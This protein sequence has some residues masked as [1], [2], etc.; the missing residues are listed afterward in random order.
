M[1]P[2]LGADAPSGTLFGHTGLKQ[3]STRS[4]RRLRAWG[5][6]S[7][8]RLRLCV[9]GRSRQSRSSSAS[10]PRVAGGRAVALRKSQIRRSAS[11]SCLTSCPSRSSTCSTQKV[12]DRWRLRFS[13]TIVNVGEGDFILRAVRNLRGGWKAEQDIPYS[14]Q[15]A[16]RVRIPA[17]LVWGGDGH[18]HWHINRVAVV[19]L[20]PLAR[21]W[22]CRTR[23]QGVRRREGRVLLLRLRARSSRAR[24]P[25]AH[26][27]RRAAE[28]R[29]GPSWE[30]ASPPVG[31]T[32]IGSRFGAVDRRDR[33][34]RREVPPF[35]RH[36]SE[37]LVPRSK[38]TEQSHVDR[39]RARTNTARTR[40]AEDQD[41]PDPRAESTLTGPFGVPRMRPGSRLGGPW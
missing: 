39:H 36:R 31:T 15:G 25:S 22:S 5:T 35:H 11:P 6:A 20:V 10:S 30:W 16:R 26:T 17:Q 3:V 28:S 27:R 32:P 8:T 24:S 14:K 19:T 9:G 33:R 41:R 13:T 21:G 1:S 18:N 23:R 34:T 4:R 37:R 40:R 2:C 7:P 38:H 12:G 29:T